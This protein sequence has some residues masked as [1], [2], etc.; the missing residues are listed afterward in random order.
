[1]HGQTDLVLGMGRFLEER[2]S[3]VKKS[4]EENQAKKGGTGYGGV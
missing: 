1:L 3:C 2:E 4:Q